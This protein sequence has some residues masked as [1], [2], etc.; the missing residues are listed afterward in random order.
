M[1]P[2]LPALTGL[3]FMAALHVVLYH[4]A[5]Q[6]LAD[7]PAPLQHIVGSGY[8]GVTM[9]FVLSGFILAYNYL[10]RDTPVAPIPFWQARFSRLYPIYAVGLLLAFV[11]FL[12][13]SA[14]DH[15]GPT[16]WG[17]LIGGG[18]ATVTL[19]QS[20]GPPLSRIWNGPGWSLSVEAFFYAVFPFL[21][22]GMRRLSLRQIACGIPLAYFASLV[23]GILYLC[24]APDGYSGWI[25]G[26]GSWMV[27]I[28]Y[29]PLARFPE[30]VVGLLAGALF[31]RLPN[32]VFPTW[33]APASVAVLLM[34]MLGRDQL[35]FILLH[36]GLLAPL[37]ALLI[38]SLA[39]GR[40][41]LS[42]LLSVR[43]LV[44]LGEAS[45]A[46]Y[47]LHV[48]LHQWTEQISLRLGFGGDESPTY[49]A[50]YVVFSI[51]VSL[52][53][54]QKIEVP[55]RRWVLSRIQGHSTQLRAIAP[56]PPG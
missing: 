42:R 56:A 14:R 1:R 7:A 3:R 45:Y 17:V 43:P 52:I 39:Q 30:F 24:L 51:S 20:W 26:Q 49:V 55:A 41:I 31:L 36:N 35:P 4:F 21:V 37:F 12:V 18:M 54:Y 27:A 38:V 2:H 8:V 48:P 25:H 22:M 34:A 11:P 29:H 28:R 47:I 6:V 32:H 53:A 10:D 13:L 19:L 44:R 33:T 50:F 46:L 9:F 23:P 16:L 15:S 40:S 5:K